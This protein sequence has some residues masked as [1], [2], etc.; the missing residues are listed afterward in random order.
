[1]KST[2][3]K[4]KFEKKLVQYNSLAYI[5]LL[6]LTSTNEQ[7]F[8]IFCCVTSRQLWIVVS[9]S[10]NGYPPW[11]YELCIHDDVFIHNKTLVRC[12]PIRHPLNII[13]STIFD[14]QLYLHFVKVVVTAY[15]WY[16]Y[17]V[18]TRLILLYSLCLHITRCDVIMLFSREN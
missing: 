15:T 1:M 14:E 11:S 18:L 17:I 13:L 5:V 16:C 7:C 10:K 3:F 12:K 2:N 4:R 6:L 8:F 9:Y